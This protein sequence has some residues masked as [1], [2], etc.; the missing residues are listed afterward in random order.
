MFSCQHDAGAIGTS[1]L[2]RYRQLLKKCIWSSLP[3]A[4]FLE[5]FCITV[6]VKSVVLTVEL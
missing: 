2:I 3:T 1:T 4:S 6:D 5:A